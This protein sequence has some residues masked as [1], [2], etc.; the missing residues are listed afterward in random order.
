MSKQT[1][2]DKKGEMEKR[3]E[4]LAAAYEMGRNA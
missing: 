1:G 3:P 2:A 4:L